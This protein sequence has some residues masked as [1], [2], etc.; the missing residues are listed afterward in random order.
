MLA[1]S[2][3][4][5]LANAISADAPS[6]PDLAY[7]AEFLEL[8]TL[9]T[10]KAEQQFGDSI[11]P[12]E[13]P[14]WGDVADKAES[15]LL[16]SKDFRAAIFLTRGLTHKEGIRG[17]VQG[18]QVLIGFSEN[19]WDT[20]HPQLDAEDN[21]DPTM[22]TN[23]LA[24]LWDHEMLLKDV[25]EAKIGGTGAATLRVKD[26]EAHFSKSYSS[27][28]AAN[29]SI[30]QVQATL[31][32]LIESTPQAFEATENSLSIVKQLQTC[33]NDKVGSQSAIDLAPLQSIVYALNQATQAAKGVA[34]SD[35]GDDLAD[36]QSSG[37]SGSSATGGALKS[38]DDAVRLLSQVITFLEKS[39]PG[40]PAPLLI[41]R[42][43]RL[44]GMNFIDII[45]DLAPD[46]LN[47]VQ[48]IAGRSDG[49]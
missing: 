8:E 6:G 9:S 23:A 27:S 7:D 26:I 4:D 42:A 40:N 32:E 34:T 41:K 17:F 38:R 31:T 12:G 14:N 10:P 30:D 48:N 21:N 33:I 44:I 28:E 20:L 15:V 3:L 11:M 29:F 13:E 37:S 2:T 25:R 49:S 43:Q 16:R 22:R 35:D 5:S 46:A 45:N 47:T 1:Q 19:F 36:G 18:L 39:E 24:A